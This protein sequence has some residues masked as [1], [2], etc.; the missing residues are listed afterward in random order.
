MNTPAIPPAA[1]APRDALRICFTN[2]SPIKNAAS[3]KRNAKSHVGGTCSTEVFMATKEPPQ[4][5]VV[6]I[7]PSAAKNRTPVPASRSC[8]FSL[9]L[10]HPPYQSGILFWKQIPLPP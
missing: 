5:M 9:T 2:K 7:N 8:F 1:H 6:T 10:P 3:V 4:T